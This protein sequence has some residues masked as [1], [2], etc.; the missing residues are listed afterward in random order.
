MEAKNNENNVLTDFSIYQWMSFLPGETSVDD[1]TVMKYSGSLSKMN[2][3]ISPDFFMPCYTIQIITSGNLSVSINNQ[4]Y[5]LSRYEGYFLS[6]DFYVKRLDSDNIAEVYILSFSRKFAKE[7]R[8][9]FKLSQIAQVHAQ[10]TWKMSEH[11]VQRLV[12]YFELLREVVEDK[13]REAALHLVY[14]FFEY[15]SS[16]TA[17]E[18][19]V[20]PNLTRN[21][22]IAG[23][24]MVLVDNHCEQQH[25]LDWYAS[26]L[27]LS[28]RYVANTVKETLGINA[29][30]FIERA[31]MQRAKN[32][33]VMTRK[34]IQEIAE[35][36]G[37]QNQSHFGTFFKRH[38]GISPA[39]YRKK[40]E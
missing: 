31:L 30:A 29:S 2:K 13:D 36:L 22:E 23:K 34:S 40:K 21:E 10:P 15:L 28:T 20:N 27:C 5:H 17:Y 14:S 25:S 1:L 18:K 16:N 4:D 12:H 33:L 7:M 32:L 6:P 35:Q 24:F 38:E 19:Q 37:F 9:E 8:M 26:E 3:V 39:A 11:K